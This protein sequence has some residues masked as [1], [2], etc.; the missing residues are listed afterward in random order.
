MHALHG[1]RDNPDPCFSVIGVHMETLRN[2]FADAGWIDRPVQEQKSAP[3]LAHDAPS[4]R[5]LAERESLQV[6]GGIDFDFF[7]WHR[8]L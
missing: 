3:T 2:P 4:R 5:R 6:R 7:G 1:K 8:F